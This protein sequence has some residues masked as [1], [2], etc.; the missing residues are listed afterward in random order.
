MRADSMQKVGIHGVPRSGTSWL[1]EIV[2]SSPHVL[3][4]YQPLFSYELKNFL[5]LKSNNHDIEDFF[6]KLLTTN[7]DF[8]DRNNEK[9]AG[10]Q[11]TFLKEN[12]THIIYKEVR[13]H[14]LIEHILKTHSQVKIVGIIR[15]PLSTLA[16]WYTAPREFRKDL[17]WI[18][19]DEWKYAT[20]K[21]EGRIEEYFGY[22]KWRNCTMLFER[23]RHEYPNRFFLIEY[24]SLIHETEKIISELFQFLELPLKEST[25]SF[26]SSSRSI[27]DNST[28]S[29]Y[30]RKKNDDNW[31]NILPNS[32]IDEVIEDV[33]SHGLS[34]YL[35]V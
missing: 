7:S 33:N 24:S 34:K 15:N 31:K 9:K 3:Y 20:R 17:G 11:P 26:C 13:Y 8:L 32:I 1:G 2:N 30:R 18:F 12:I 21:N 5:S 14:H 19:S 35:S 27:S 23:L 25:T 6:D 28:Y 16:S 29:V 4:K 10:L 22:F